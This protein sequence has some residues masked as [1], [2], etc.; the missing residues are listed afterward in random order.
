L[1]GV[2][3]CDQVYH[4]EDQLSHENESVAD[5]GDDVKYLNLPYSI[6]GY[7]SLAHPIQIPQQLQKLSYQHDL[8]V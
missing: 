2:V 7:M 5:A 4:E 8:Q 6:S 1:V 3:V